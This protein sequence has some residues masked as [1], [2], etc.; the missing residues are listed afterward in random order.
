MKEVFE[1]MYGMSFVGAIW[2]F[3]ALAVVHEL[4]EWNI[5]RFERRLFEG[6]PAVHSDRNARAWIGV[7]CLIGAL[8]SGVASLP[9]SP[10]A[11]AYI[12]LPLAF[13]LG[14]NALQHVYWSLL[15]RILA[16]GTA[17]GFLLILPSGGYLVFLAL[18]RGLV[19]IWY[20]VGLS[21]FGFLAL[22]GTVRGGRRTPSIIAG[23]YGIG[24]RAARLATGGGKGKE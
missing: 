17:S 1:S 7:A 6:L 14:A 13:F 19:P 18:D 22:A 24:D 23:I 16:P 4:E 8:V 3:Y 20:V 2:V 12:I 9:A 21:V 10:T 15:S 5:A 11:S